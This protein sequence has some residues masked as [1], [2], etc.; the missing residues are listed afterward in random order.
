M[1]NA[2]FNISIRCHYPNGNQTE[3]RQDLKLSDIPKW[4]D[5]YKFTHP[6]CKSVSFKIWFS[7]IED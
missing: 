6:D 3:H 4:I 5:A 1:K 7:D 2:V